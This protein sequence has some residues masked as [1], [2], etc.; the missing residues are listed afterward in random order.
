MSPDNTKPR[1]AALLLLL[2]TLSDA[3]FAQDIKARLFAEADEALRSADAVRHM[4]YSRVAVVPTPPGLST[5]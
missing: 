5:S 4:L 2:F 3:A 1:V